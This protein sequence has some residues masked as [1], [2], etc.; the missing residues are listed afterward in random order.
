VDNKS[1][2]RITLV[3]L[4]DADTQFPERLEAQALLEKIG[5]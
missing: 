2:A 3:K 4:L 1:A 5:N